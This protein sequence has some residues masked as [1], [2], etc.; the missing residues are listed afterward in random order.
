VKDIGNKSPG[1]TRDKFPDNPQLA[2][3]VCRE[4]QYSNNKKSSTGKPQFF[5]PVTFN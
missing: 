3:L 2:K 1:F 5:Q 4:N